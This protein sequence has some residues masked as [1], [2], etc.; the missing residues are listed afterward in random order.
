MRILFAGMVAGTPGHGG[1]TWSVLQ[2]LLGFRRL[3][4]DVLLV[5]PVREASPET[6]DYLGRFIAAFGLVGRAALLLGD[7]DETVGTE[8]GEVRECA[9]SADLLVNVSGMLRDPSLTEPIG[10]RVY[11]DLD[12]AFNQLW[13]EEGID[14]GFAGHTHFVSV[15]QAL[16]RP[17]CPVPTGGIQWIPTAQP[18]VLERWPV[19]EELEYEGLTTVANWRGYGSVEH[20]G[21]H[22][23]QKAHSF[24]RFFELPRRTDVPVFAGLA[25]DPDERDD[26]LAL[27]ENGWRLIDPDEAAG[28]PDRYR[29]FVRGSW[30]ELGIAKSGYVASRCGW[31]SDR[32]VCYLASG[33]PVLAQE[34]GFSDFLPTGE[35]LLVFETVDDVLAG[36]GELRRDY[37]RHRRAARAI[38]EDVFDSDK[39][40]PRLLDVVGGS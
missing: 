26:L 38:A 12:P 5:E 22:Y 20:D 33:R 13:H 39:V 4:H 11:L 23:G 3:G 36:V 35:G 32:S 29:R 17:S 30:A 14:V 9:E 10:R 24:R 7:A 31:F 27:R 19:A 2:Y 21:V 25:I 37:E 28:T 34:T 16:G 40:L 8:R 18:V 1:A 15:G 6:M